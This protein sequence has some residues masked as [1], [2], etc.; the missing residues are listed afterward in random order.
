MTDKKT[1]IVYYSRSGVTKKVAN[2]IRDILKCDIEEIKDTKKRSGFLG[3]LTAGRDAMF[4]RDTVLE[5]TTDPSSYDIVLIGTPV[6]AGNMS[7]PIG[8]YI[9]KYKGKFND[10]AFFTTLGS[11]NTSKTYTN[12]EKFSEK[13]PLAK[14]TLNQKEVENDEYKKS[15]DE[16]IQEIIGNAINR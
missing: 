15:L 14:L 13:S 1:L 11:A 6:W 2:A 9:R 4:N 7:C 8:T 12:M 5:E 10:V 16:F 3:F